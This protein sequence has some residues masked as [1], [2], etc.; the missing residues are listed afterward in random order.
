[1][2]QVG[3][4]TRLCTCR[5]G[6][7]SG[8]LLIAIVITVDFMLVLMKVAQV[9]WL[10]RFKLTFHNYFNVRMFRLL[11]GTGWDRSRLRLPSVTQTQGICVFKTQT[12][13]YVAHLNIGGV[14]FGWGHLCS[15]E[16]QMTQAG[17]EA[18]H[19]EPTNA[20]VQFL[21]CQWIVFRDWRGG[22]YG[23]LDINKDSHI[24]SLS[25]IK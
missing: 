25:G 10:R 3:V 4:E 20:K 5:R 22:G 24:F 15:R 6:Y 17:V 13:E 12:Q 18:G 21:E 7:H 14:L 2:T 19:Y 1:M 23:S 11:R 8:C 9:C 16:G